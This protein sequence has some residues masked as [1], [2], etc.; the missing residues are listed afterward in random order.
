MYVDK[1][2]RTVNN[3]RLEGGLPVGFNGEWTGD[4]HIVAF[5]VGY[6]F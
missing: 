2:D 1:K 6:K 4:S 5:D 3:Q